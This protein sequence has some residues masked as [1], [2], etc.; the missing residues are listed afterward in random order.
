MSN[1]TVT[2]PKILHKI[3]QTKKQ[4]N[5]YSHVTPVRCEYNDIITITYSLTEIK[6]KINTCSICQQANFGPKP[7]KTV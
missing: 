6:I 7:P 5:T 3:T 4:H 1:S 2:K